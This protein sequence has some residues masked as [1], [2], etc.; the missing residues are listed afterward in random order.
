MN[1][2]G[3]PRSRCDL[4]RTDASPQYAGIRPHR[5]ASHLGPARTSQATVGGADPRT[6]LASDGDGGGV[7]VIAESG[8][9]AARPSG[10]ETTFK[11]HAESFC[12]ADHPRRLLEDAQAIV[13]D[14]LAALS[15]SI[16]PRD[17]PTARP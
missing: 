9:F 5:G 1:H 16:L 11:I 10:T 3:W 15:G 13:D 12:G 4:P 17:A 14:A 6:G 2:S 8:W 7:K